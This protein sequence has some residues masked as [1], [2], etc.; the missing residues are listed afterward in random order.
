MPCY[1]KVMV[2]LSNDKWTVEA[3]KKLGLPLTGQVSQE[4]AIRIKVEAG[5]LKTAA[6]IRALNPS[7]MI[8]GMQAGSCKINIQVNI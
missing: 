3:R 8:T 1:T 6:T 7:A 2:S 5:K 4:D